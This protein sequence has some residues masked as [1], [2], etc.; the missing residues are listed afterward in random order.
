MRKWLSYKLI[1]RPVEKELLSARYKSTSNCRKNHYLDTSY[2]FMMPEYSSALPQDA[3]ET[4]NCHKSKNIFSK[5]N[6]TKSESSFAKTLVVS[7]NIYLKM[8]CLKFFTR[9]CYYH[10]LGSG[11]S[12]FLHIAAFLFQKLPFSKFMGGKVST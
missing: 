1:Y 6:C 4:C 11:S 8:F 10:N 3:V 7:L 9:W 12:F 5:K 2:S